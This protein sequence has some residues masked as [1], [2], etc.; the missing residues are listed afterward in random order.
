MNLDIVYKWALLLKLFNFIKVH[1]TIKG[2]KNP[3]WDSE[4]WMGGNMKHNILLITISILF[5]LMIIFY[6]S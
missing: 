2:F 5:I 1:K 6:R 3:P 4:E